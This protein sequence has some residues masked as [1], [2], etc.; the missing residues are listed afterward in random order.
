MGTALLRRACENRIVGHLLA[1][2]CVCGYASGSLV[3]G[4]VMSGVGDLFVCSDCNP[5]SGSL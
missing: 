3:S 5:N 4:G 2:R 1:L